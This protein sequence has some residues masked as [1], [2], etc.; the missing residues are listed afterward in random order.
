[1][2]IHH[3]MRDAHQDGA[4]SLVEVLE[5]ERER[6]AAQAAYALVHLDRW[7]ERRKASRKAEE[8]DGPT[9]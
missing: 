5:G 4:P 2:L 6:T 9:S 1:M 3:L 8:E 7:T